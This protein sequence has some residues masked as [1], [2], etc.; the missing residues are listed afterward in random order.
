MY[1]KEYL[2]NK[3]SKNEIDIQDVIKLEFPNSKG[4]KIE[5]NEITWWW[6]NNEDS[7][8]TKTK[9]DS[10]LE[11]LKNEWDKYQYARDRKREYP[12]FETQLDNIYHNGIEVWKSNILAIKT[13]YPKGE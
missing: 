4:Y 2:T 3:L 6:E 8:P 13:K 5:K 1:R 12:L 9:L 11:G 7:K 10:L